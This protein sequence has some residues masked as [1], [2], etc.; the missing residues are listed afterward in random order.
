LGTCS[1][2]SCCL[3]RQ[4]QMTKRHALQKLDYQIAVEVSDGAHATFERKS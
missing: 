4:Q 2:H 3:Y 1:L